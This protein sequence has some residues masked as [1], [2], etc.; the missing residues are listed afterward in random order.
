MNNIHSTA[1]L[2][3]TNIIECTIGQYSVIGDQSTIRNSIIQDY[4]SVDRQNFVLNSSL[5]KRTYTGRW[6]MIFHSKIGMYNSISY[7][8]TIGP[9]EHKYSRVSTHPFIYDPKFGL[10][11]EDDDIRSEKFVQELIIGNDVWIGCNSTVLRGVK[12][13]D[14]SIIAANAVVTKDVP[15]YAI[16]AGVPAKVIKF[17]FSFDVIDKLLELQW[18]NWSD[19]RIQRNKLFFKCKEVTIELLNCIQ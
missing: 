9:P 17:R 8:V 2:Y 18:W 14:G 6:D 10:L 4:C 16:V 3:S 5:G 13:G 19:E 7:G 15:P 11:S 1:R 12:V